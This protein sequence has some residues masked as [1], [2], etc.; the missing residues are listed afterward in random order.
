MR[1]ALSLHILAIE[2]IYG[3][4][5]RHPYI[6]STL[7]VV[8]RY[9]IGDLIA[10]V[11]TNAVTGE[12]SFDM[13]RSAIF[14]CFGAWTGSYNY[15]F[16]SKFYP[17]VMASTRIHPLVCVA[18]EVVFT[19]PLIY[20]PMFYFAKHW[21]ETGAFNPALGWRVSTEKRSADRKAVMMF[22]GPMN[23]FSFCY[24][25][26]SM[27][28]MFS[29]VVGVGWVVL[30]SLMR[31]EHGSCTEEPKDMSISVEKVLQTG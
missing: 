3:F 14:T 25:T 15:F 16:F 19:M 30:L 5:Y 7:L 1:M 8:L 6:A 10:Q 28:G 31:G 29:A 22:W 23:S 21:G 9:F 12:N 2:R 18:V 26:A 13:T 4:C 11:G 24:V 20:Y 27:R 17:L